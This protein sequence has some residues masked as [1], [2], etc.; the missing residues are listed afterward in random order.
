VDYSFKILR[1]EI[2][3][4]QG[5]DWETTIN[6]KEFDTNTKAEAFGRI[7]SRTLH[8]AGQMAIKKK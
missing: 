8:H 5:T 4:Q 6:A 1:S 7:I 3:M 2:E